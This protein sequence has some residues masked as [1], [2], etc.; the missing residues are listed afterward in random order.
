MGRS[1]NKQEGSSGGYLIQL[2]TIALFVILLA[3][4]ILLN[5]IAVTDE[6]KQ[7][8]VIDSLI[9]SFGAG[10]EQD[11]GQIFDDN[12]S[13][14]GVSP[15]DL[16]DLGQGTVP[17]VKDIKV[18]VGRKRTTLSVSSDK[19]FSGDGLTFTSTGEGVLD[20]IAEIIQKNQ[21][22]VDIEAHTNKGAPEGPADMG[23]RALTVLESL[24]I[25]KYFVERKAISSERLTAVGWGNAKPVIPY[26]NK[27]AK[28]M[29]V[30]VDF[31]F[32]HESTLEKPRGFMI[33]KDFFFNVKDR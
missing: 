16:S 9:E 4:F 22:T 27:E 3:F 14:N 7:R 19:M 2:M 25:M 20:L 30:R 29:N 26:M 32:I 18:S 23:G 12:A 6:K 31:S 15:V 21:C 17:G 1:E 24:A 8:H 5:A 28:S 33:F 10:K 13:V 11:S